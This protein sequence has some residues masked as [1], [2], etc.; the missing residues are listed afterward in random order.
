[1]S[2]ELNKDM[3]DNNMSETLSRQVTL[4]LSPEQYERLFFQPS[5]AKGD[6]AKRL[7]MWFYHFARL[8]HRPVRSYGLLSFYFLLDML[9]DTIP[10]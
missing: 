5:V 2:N 4:Q 7:G 6:L 9:A 3:R 10:R 1:M 8:S